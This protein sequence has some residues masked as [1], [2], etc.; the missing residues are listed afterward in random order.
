[1]NKLLLFLIL[2]SISCNVQSQ[3]FDKY[4]D[5]I[6]S[7]DEM[8]I[9][10]DKAVKL[11][12]NKDY[13]GFRK[14]FVP[15]FIQNFSEEQ[16]IYTVNQIHFL[17]EEEGI[18]SGNDN[19]LPSLNAS[20]N[21]NDTIFVNNILYKFKPY[22]EAENPFQRVLLFSFL[23]KHGTDQLVGI[24]VTTN[25]LSAENTQPSIKPFDNFTFD[26]S[27]ISYFRIFYDEGSNRKTKFKNEVG[28]FAMEGNLTTLENSGI[29]PIIETIFSDLTKF[30][31]KKSTIFNSAI[32]RGNAKFI[33]ISLVFNDNI[34]KNLFIYLPIENGGKYAN[35]IIL[36]QSEYANLGYEFILD[37]KDYPKIMQEFPKIAQMN[38]NHYY[39]DKP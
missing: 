28:F 14:L 38:L 29:K 3:N 18:P 33:Q 36:R 1:M 23:K 35:K 9:T 37:Q 5:E 22:T 6:L 34:S 30:K 39:L 2:F 25:Y 15:E 31:F 16:L 17:F 12:Q 13:K 10:T 20:I 26:V 7:E 4:R 27:D 19:I 32:N 11:I 21:G 24:D 8:R